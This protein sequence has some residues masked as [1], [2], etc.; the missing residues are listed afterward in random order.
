MLA[1][2]VALLCCSLSSRAEWKGSVNVDATASGIYWTNGQLPPDTHAFRDIYTLRI[3][4][5]LKNGRALRFRFQPLVEAD[6]QNASPVDPQ[7]PDRNERYFWDIQEG[8]VQLQSL[9][10]TAQIG[11]NVITWG[12]TDVANPL[13]VVN[14]RR[15]YDPM[16]SEKLGAPMVLV[17]HEGEKI[18]AEAIY[19]PW[20]TET[21]VP[22]ESSRWL[23]RDV[24]KSRAFEG[25][26]VGNGTFLSGT[27]N[28]P[29]QFKYHYGKKAVLNAATRDNFGA[30]VKLRLSGFDWTLAGF[31]GAAPAPSVNITDIP[32]ATLVLVPGT[33]TADFNVG[34]DVYLQSLFYKNRMLGTSFVWA[35][36]EYLIKG[37]S[38][39]N[40]VVSEL[41][42]SVANRLP[43]DSWENV[44]GVEHTF[45]AGKGTLTALVQGTYVKRDEKLDTN[46]VSL[47]RMFDRAAM[48]GLRWAPSERWTAV[49]SVLWDIQYKGNLE[50]L[51]ASYKL[52]DGWAARLAGDLLDGRPETPLGTYKRNDRIL[53]SV[54]MQK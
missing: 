31:Q 44:L 6:P 4:T 24:Y 52:A 23:P 3:P 29:S 33:N 42:G 25:E 17:R 37:A 41:H 51:E 27:V 50:H 28:L 8:F 32:S 2:V 13:D 35:V 20:Q 22:G 11:M 14:A 9:P 47:A 40:H 34:P 21:L 5:T 19:I 49:A 45:P 54:S 36:G 38:A 30:R 15:Y 48:L 12:D 16:R 39:Q 1:V 18:L 43:K 46:S 7:H 26:S 10:W 53:L